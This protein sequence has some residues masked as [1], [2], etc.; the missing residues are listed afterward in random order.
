MITQFYLPTPSKVANKTEETRQMAALMYFMLYNMI[1]RKPISQEKCANLFKVQYS[2]SQRTVSGRRQPG[3]SVIEKA[4]KLKALVET[5]A[6]GTP[7]APK[8]RSKT[9]TTKGGTP[10][11]S[12][13]RGKVG[14]K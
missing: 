9:R 1:M 12:Q 4:K 6:E 11:S 3:G 10:K 14:K 5:E 2:S 8:T 7:S 13:G